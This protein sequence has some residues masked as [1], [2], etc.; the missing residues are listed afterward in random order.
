[1]WEEGAGWLAGGSGFLGPPR[2]EARP[3]LKRQFPVALRVLLFVPC[4]KSFTSMNPPYSFLS[5]F[6]VSSCSIYFCHSS[7]KK[8]ELLALLS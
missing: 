4:S 1:M 2:P 8:Q 3:A 7:L 6:P 5:W